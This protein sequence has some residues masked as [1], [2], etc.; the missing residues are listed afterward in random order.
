MTRLMSAIA[1]FF[2][3]AGG[4]AGDESLDAAIQ[5]VVDKAVADSGAP[6]MV[7]AIG[8]SS[9]A[10]AT[11]AAG[12]R[13]AGDKTALAAGDKMHLGSCTKAMTATLLGLLVD[14]GK[15]AW[16]SKLVDAAPELKPRV[17]DDYHDVTLWQ[18]VTHRAGF[19]A[20]ANWWG[21]QSL[22][23]H[24]RRVAL[25]GEALAAAPTE[26]IGEHHYSNVGYTAAGVMAE[27]ITG[28]TWEELMRERL[29][30]PL[31]MSSAGFGPPGAAGKVDQPWGH[32]KGWLGFG[33]W[34]PDQTDNAPALGPAGTVHCSIEDWAKFLALHLGQGPDPT[35]KPETLAKLHTPEEGDEAQYAGGWLLQ[36]RAWGEGEVLWHNGS[37][38]LWYALVWIAPNTDRSYM[39]VTNSADGGSHSVCDGVIAEMI[40]LDRAAGDSPPASE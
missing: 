12:V 25:V 27:A 5:R 40:R 2:L 35:L 37:N 23:M 26:P 13:K 1:T 19:P 32:R 36:E 11:G 4:A 29:F 15:L 38:T 8:D 9:G 10:I 33:G 39:V 21:K 30:E 20:N 3:I 7:A 28:K 17:H 6:G 14:E 34:T 31:E 22:P 16:D 24:E 18:L